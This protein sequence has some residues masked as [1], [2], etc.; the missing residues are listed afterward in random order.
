VL[1]GGG[2]LGVA[3]LGRAALAQGSYPTRPVTV[4]IGYAPGGLTDTMSRLICERMSRELGQP[5]VVENRTG[6]ATSIASA[7]VA[8]AR[9]DGHTLLM[10]TTSLAINP[11]LQPNLP[12]REPL[13]ELA[14]VGTAYESPFLLLV[15]AQ[16]PIR[17][18]GGFLTFARANPGRLELGSS[19]TGAVN[20]L[21]L[22]MLAR[23]AGVRLEHIPYR[24]AAPALTDLRAGRIAATFATPLDA[25]PVAQDGAGRILAVT[26]RR[27]LAAMP[28]VPAV[29]ETLPNVH[30]T[31]WQ[32]LFAPSGTPDAIIRRLAAALDTAIRDPDLGRRAADNG[33]VMQPG[34]P[35]AMRQ[36][37]QSET[38]HW[39]RLIS[40]ANIRAD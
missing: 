19:G 24:G 7:H 35:D 1:A 6:G 36:L 33:L 20:H 29:A 9:P 18:L 5:V 13:R 28:E 12:P 40:A 15:N 38:E 21:L 22:E 10:G 23:E 14:P 17:D 34:G 26:S 37:L 16:L 27:R 25:V 8:Q 4:V 30:G 39:S 11:A 3:V 2:G 32:G 31:F